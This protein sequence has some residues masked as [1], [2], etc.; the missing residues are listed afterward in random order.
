R[1]DHDRPLPGEHRRA[2]TGAYPTLLLDGGASRGAG[3][4]RVRAS[5][6]WPPRRMALPGGPAERG[7]PGAG[8]ALR[9]SEPPRPGHR[10][11]ARGA[12]ARGGARGGNRATRRRLRQLRLGA[13]PPLLRAARLPSLALSHVHRPEHGRT[14]AAEA[15]VIRLVVVSP[16]RVIK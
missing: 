15:G 14:A 7:V 10:R 12:P 13:D 8:A 9:P 5:G 1:A 6:G 11:G 2:A 3:R 16:S 4:L